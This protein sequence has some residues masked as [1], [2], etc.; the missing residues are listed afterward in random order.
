ML[1]QYTT[2]T[3]QLL[4]NPAAQNALYATADIQNWIN[5]ARG[6]VAADGECLRVQGTLALTQGQR[7]Y[8][9]SSINLGTASSN[10]VQGAIRIEQIL[11]TVAS[12]YTWMRPRPF[13]WFTIYRLN[14][15]VPAQGQPNEWS[16]YGQGS[17]PQPSA[18]FAGS[19]GSIYIDPVPD[20]AYTLWVD[21][22]CYP[23]ALATDSDPEA[24]PYLFTDAVAYYAAYLALLSAQTNA[25]QA[26]AKRYFDIYQEF[27]NKARRAATP[28]V[29][30]TG[31]VGAPD[32]T[33]GNKLGIQSRAGAG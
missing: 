30:P 33:L 32:L 5:Q 10:G 27:I 7:A 29:Y 28:S 15:P 18:Q 12:G 8:S 6:W 17:A 31:F 21:C 22:L 13:P 24:L 2:R 4:Q 3:Q 14:N 25:R 23:L 20:Q 16:Q 1:T 19:G 26:D 9:F 11:L